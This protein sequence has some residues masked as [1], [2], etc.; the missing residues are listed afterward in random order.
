MMKFRFLVSM[1]I[2]REKEWAREGAQFVPALKHLLEMACRSIVPTTDSTWSVEPV[3]PLKPEAAGLSWR[4]L[5]GGAGHNRA[6]A[7]PGGLSRSIPESSRFTR[8]VR[9]LG[10]TPLDLGFVLGLCSFGAGF[11]FCRLLH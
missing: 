7:G 11:L 5:P 2:P 9:W 3:T 10:W 6:E 1:D 4:E 8:V